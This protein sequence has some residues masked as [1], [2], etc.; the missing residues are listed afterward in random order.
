MEEISWTDHVKNEV[1][2]I[3]REERNIVPAIKRKNAYWIGHMSSGNC[4][5]KCIIEGKI[6]E[7]NR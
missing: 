7:I 3:V 6:E 2:P 1:V 4:L 5:L